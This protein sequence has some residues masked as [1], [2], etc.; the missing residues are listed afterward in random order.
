MH[1]RLARP[2]YR[3]PQSGTASES[4][5]ALLR[6]DRHDPQRPARISGAI[7]VRAALAVKPRGLG[8]ARNR[9]M[10]SEPNAMLELLELQRA[11]QGVFTGPPAPESRT[12][13]FGGQVL[14]QALA[15]A[16]FSVDGVPCHSLHAYFLR[17]GKPARPIDY[18]VQAMRDGQSFAA[19]KVIAVQ[20]DEV[21]LELVAS[22][23][24]DE[25]GPEHQSAMPEV[26]P[27]EAF[28]AEDVRLEGLLAQAP[29]A[30]H[31]MIRQKRPIES[32]RVDSR[33]MFTEAKVAMHTQTWMRT[34]G[35][36]LGDPNL[37]RCALAYA[38]D[39]G[40]LEPSVRAIGAS[41]GDSDTQVA[42]LDHALWFHRPFRFDDWLLFDFESVSVAGGRGLSRGAVY[43]RSGTLVA[44]IAQEG[45]MRKRSDRAER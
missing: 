2:I 1:A 37:H 12:R 28:P 29:P 30:L 14:A 8:D 20:R 31:E 41:F 3:C 5:V 38:S 16:C 21:V 7:F 36:L 44:S 45:V 17:P 43:D 34:R 15:A 23:A 32:I 33:D 24:H 11:A 27:P 26:P 35:A 9:R 4:D 13:V 42:S 40:A 18:E 22:F 39:L 19:R 10:T 25:P 6:H